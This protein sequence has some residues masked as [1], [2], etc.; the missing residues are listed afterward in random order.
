ML[1]LIPRRPTEVLPGAVELMLPLTQVALL[2][3][4]AFATLNWGAGVEPAKLLVASTEFV[5]PRLLPFALLPEG[6]AP[7]RVEEGVRHPQRSVRDFQIAA[8]ACGRIR[9]GGSI[10]GCVDLG[11]A[12]VGRPHEHAARVCGDP[13]VAP[14]C[15]GMHDER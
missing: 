7:N 12:G 9:C 5:W 1:L 10:G 6:L 8:L 15:E 3:V 11:D 14:R 4:D 2:S 13:D